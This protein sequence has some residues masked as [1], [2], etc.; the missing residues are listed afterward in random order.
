LLEQEV[1][2]RK[3]RDLVT[4]KR[5]SEMLQKSILAYRNKAITASVVIAELVELAKQMK[6]ED[7]KASNM[8]IREDELA[9]YNALTDDSVARTEMDHEKLLAI[10]HELVELVRRDAK[11]DWNLKEQVRASLRMKIRALLSRHGY[12]PETSDKAT[13]LVLSQA[14]LFADL[15]NA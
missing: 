7:A 5:F 4:S 12:P 13:K 15:V 9:F 2:T 3:H 8:G 11:T 6:A 1:S 10:A 14:E